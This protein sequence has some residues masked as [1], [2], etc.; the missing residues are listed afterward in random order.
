M[1]DRDL[2]GDM[3]NVLRWTPTADQLTAY[4]AQRARTTEAMVEA[5][6]EKLDKLTALVEA[7]LAKEG[8]SHDTD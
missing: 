6:G 5:I 7:L 1:I 3:L 4:T 8:T 2:R